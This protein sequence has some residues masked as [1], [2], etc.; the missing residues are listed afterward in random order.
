MGCCCS[1]PGRYLAQ[2]IASTCL[3][4][5]QVVHV[6]SS[7]TILCPLGLLAALGLS[8]APPHS[9]AT[10]PHPPTPAPSPCLPVCRVSEEQRAGQC[11]SDAVSQVHAAVHVRQQAIAH[12][13]R[14]AGSSS[15][16]GP[17]ADSSASCQ[18]QA[19]SLKT[20]PFSSAVSGQL[21]RLQL[22]QLPA[23]HVPAHAV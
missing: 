18:W 11:A 8:P 22:C 20:N 13:V 23:W 21:D 5:P 10:P 15:K 16:I 17:P 7:D 9:T 6:P 4:V 12:A 3:V 1:P 19:H 14:L 2:S